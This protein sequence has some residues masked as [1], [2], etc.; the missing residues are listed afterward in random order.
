MSEYQYY[1][2]QAIDRPFTEEERAEIGTWS[3]RTTPTSTHAI[4]MYNYGDFPH[5]VKKV[6]E[7]Y[8]DAMLYLTNWGTKR[9]M[10]RLPRTMVDTK[11]LQP[12]CSFEGVRLS[13]TKHHLI[14]DMCFDDEEGGGWVD[15]EGW[16]SSLITLRND[17]INGDLRTLYLA[18]LHSIKQEYD[19]KASLQELEPPVPEG[20]RN[21]TASLKSFIDFFE[22][23]RDLISAASQASNKKQSESRTIGELLNAAKKLA[24]QRKQKHRQKERQERIKRITEL[25][26]QEPELWKKVFQLIA[27]RQPKAYDQAV[28]I[29]KQLREVSEHLEQVDRFNATIEQIHQD[30]SSLSGLK[31][32]LNRAGLA[33]KSSARR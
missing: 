16:L 8:F 21:L 26:K 5:E 29:L 17:L 10:F 23:D 7:K 27:L 12:F 31:S 15:G 1:E 30:N 24:D 13:N 2:F 28:D 4:F 18:W 22:I 32:R 9:L 11:T 20:L 6:V 33:S 14:L 25:T 3:S 19:L